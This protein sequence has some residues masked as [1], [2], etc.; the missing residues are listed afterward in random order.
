VT[1]RVHFVLPQMT[2]YYGMEKAAALLMTALAQHGGHVSAT[3]LSGGVPPIAADLPI[4]TLDIPRSPI[5]LASAVPALRRRLTELPERTPIVA[6]GL[7]AAAPVAAALLGTGR[8]YIAWEHSVLPPRLRIDR[9]VAL[10][11]RL[12]D[13]PALRPARVV[14][15]S[16]GVRRAM[17][18]RWP[19]VPTSVVPNII[20]G[21]DR[22]ATPVVAPREGQD[23]RLVTT[24]A[25]RPS[26]N[27]RCAIEAM[28]LL[29]NRYTLRMA[30]DG[31]QS[32]ALR[33]LVEGLGLT[34]R[35]E[36]LGWVSAVAPLLA[37][38]HLLVHPSLWETFGFSLVEAADAGVPVVTLAAPAI[39]ELVPDYVPGVMADG[40]TAAALAAAI[41][42]AA[43][44]AW[45][46]EQ[47]AAAWHRRRTGFAAEA[48]AEQW[49]AAL[50]SA[51]S[52][53][54]A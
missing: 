31:R 32:R 40:R 4:A 17:S 33:S 19:G 8:S 9:R 11:L 3:V 49:H 2:P 53:P 21:V 50:Q 16:D 22:P 18:A 35:V 45:D 23:V 46:A 14:A 43:E 38:S 29:P 24:G 48:V 12:V 36:L 52:G 41:E 20:E 28:A 15:V 39:D 1:E 10:L 25:F 54:P 34:D 13:P 6:C 7:W 47:V 51:G 27:Y 37:D 26:K 5:R 30:G 44:H 42:T